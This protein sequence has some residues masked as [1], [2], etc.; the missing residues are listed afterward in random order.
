M[1]FVIES[2]IFLAIFCSQML[3]SAKKKKTQ[4]VFRYHI[5]GLIKF[6]FNQILTTLH[7]THTAM[8][9]FLC[10]F[11]PSVYSAYYVLRASL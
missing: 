9:T 7:T 10:S 2:I 4:S 5:C 11:Y 8:E 3:L 6:T 1:L